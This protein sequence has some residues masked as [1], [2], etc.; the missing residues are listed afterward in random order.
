M[1]CPMEYGCNFPN[2]IPVMSAPTVKNANEHFSHGFHSQLVEIDA[3]RHLL[4]MISGD[5][6]EIR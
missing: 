6:V 3:N 4:G 5:Y 1:N 2:N